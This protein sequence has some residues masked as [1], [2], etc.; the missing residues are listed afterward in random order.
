[1]S[2]PTQVFNGTPEGSYAVIDNGQVGNNGPL[3]GGGLN[4]STGAV[5]QGTNTFS[6]GNVPDSV[7][8]ATTIINNAQLGIF[9]RFKNPA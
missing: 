6:N 3:T 4:N 7:Q 2:Q 1:M 8:K 9:I 5:S